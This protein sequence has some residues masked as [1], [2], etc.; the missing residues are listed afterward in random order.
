MV[1]GRHIR[2]SS[3]HEKWSFIMSIYPFSIWFL[4][5]SF[6]ALTISF[7]DSSV[8]CFIMIILNCKNY[9]G[10]FFFLILNKSSNFFR[11]FN[12]LGKFISFRAA[13]FNNHKYINSDCCIKKFL[14]YYTIPTA[15]SA[16]NAIKNKICK[17]KLSGQSFPCSVSG[18]IRS[19][20]QF[21]LKLFPSVPV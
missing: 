18:I 3:I 2:P 21:A 19:Q 16:I 12:I 15:I 20:F 7:C 11:F 6:I 1:W 10:W 14:F 9:L 4:F 5:C 17:K 13:R 8:P